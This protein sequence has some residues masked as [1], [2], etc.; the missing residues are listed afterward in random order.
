MEHRHRRFVRAVTAPLLTGVI[1]IALLVACGGE[2]GTPGTSPLSL[3]P[4]PRGSASATPSATMTDPAGPIVAAVVSTSPL[5]EELKQAI[6]DRADLRLVDSVEAGRAAVDAGDAT[7]VVASLDPSEPVPVDAMTLWSR[8]FALVVPFTFRLEAV[9]LE[10]AAAIIDG[11]V[12]DWSEVG[13]PEGAI[14]A[15]EGAPTQ[16]DVL[17]QPWTG[18]S[19]RSKPLRVDGLA[20]DDNAYPLTER[21]VAIGAPPGITPDPLP[22]PDRDY[23]TLAAVGD[24][25]FARTVGDNIAADGSDGFVGERRIADRWATELGLSHW[26]EWR[27]ID[28]LP[29]GYR[30]TSE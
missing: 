27:S 26:F 11:S 30:H 29:P 22:S 14:I 18:P 1:L 5:P 13:G 23:V 8:P 12:N 15:A 25:M 6:L 20:P 28:A 17:M 4:R 21:W 7:Y 3:T 10:D 19:L 24:M 9:S 16:G 2:G